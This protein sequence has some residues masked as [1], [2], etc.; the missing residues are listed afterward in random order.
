M[1]GV[2]QEKGS[3]DRAL[4]ASAKPRHPEQRQ[5]P[6]TPGR[7]PEPFRLV[8]TTIW[9]DPRVR[10]ELAREAKERN[11]SLSQ[12]GAI[13]CRDWV[14]YEIYRQQTSL[15]EAKLR[16]IVRE[17]LR[18]LA[19]R[20][21]YFELRTALASE[22][23]R[24]LTTDLYKRSLSAADISPA[25]FYELLDQ[26]DEMARSNILRRSPKFTALLKEWEALGTATKEGEA[27]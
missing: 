3:E 27:N 25:R 23:T 21:V 10:A 9:L 8:H 7:S 19:D 22:Q 17:E 4:G 5:R 1:R 16:E 2:V 13:A 18:A 24:V 12:V 20:L 15:F 14:T 26:S 6:A 11:L